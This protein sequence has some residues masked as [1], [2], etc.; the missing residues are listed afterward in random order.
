M[1]AMENASSCTKSSYHQSSSKQRRSG[2]EPSDTETDWQESPWNEGLSISNRPRTPPGPARAISPLN[3]SRR[4]TLKEES[5]YPSVKA[6]GTSSATRR[7]SRSP[8]KPIRGAGDVPYSD[9]RRN[10]SPLKVSEHRRHVSPYKAK[11]E[12]SEH[13]NSELNN[14]FRK[15][16]QRTPPKIHNS[17]QNDTHSQL[18]EVSR[19]NER[20]KY[21]RNRSMSTPKLRARETTIHDQK[22]GTYAGS[23][24]PKEINEVIAS[25]KLSKSPS[26]D[27]HLTKSTDSVSFGDIFFSRDCTIPQKNSDMNNSNNGKNFAPG[28]KAVLERNATLHQESRGIKSSDQNRQAI[29]VRTVLSQTNTSFVSAAGQLS[30]GQTNTSS[31]SAIGRLSR[32]SNDTG[33]FSDGSGKSGSFRKF[34]ANIQRSQTEAWLSC[35]RKGSCRKS[36]LPEYRAIDEASFIEK[37]FVVEELRMFWADKHRPHSLNGFICHKQQTQHLRQLI[38][39]N[40]FPHLLFKGPSGSGKKSLCMAFLHEIFGDSSLK[41]SHDLRHFH[42]QESRPVQI[43]VPLT[44]GPHHFELNLKSQSKNARYA[45]MALVKEIVGNCAD[46][47]EVS[48][49]SLKMNYKVIVLH[50]V[51]KATENV[52]HLIKWIMD[53]YTDA[54]KI[55]LCCEDDTNLLHSIKSRCKL[56]AMDA[57]VTH[58]MM[59]VLIQI[60]KKENFELSTSFAARIATRSKQNLRRAIMALEACKA[61]NYPFVDDQPMP[62]DWEDVLGE[63]AAEILADPSPKRL[64][65][66]RGKLQKLLVEFV[67]PKLIL[68]KLVE[69][70]LKGIEAGLKRELYYWHAYYDKRLPTGTSALLKLEEFVAKFMSIHRKSF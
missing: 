64:F 30:S 21:S 13:E 58:E 56:I 27:A 39:H 10:T 35:V 51:D 31:N 17:A 7:H 12:Q 4:N 22:D 54:C 15:R 47:P 14:S 48:D 70:F 63:L 8:Y 11:T 57:P 69:Q 25:R 34:T 6:L 50:D 40:S 29:S 33:K 55:I 67:H 38:S 53:C 60:A 45:L 37:A 5:N 1:L 24:S 20:S 59:E 49:A 66:I 43:V 3:H 36:K 18:Q 62:L 9:L 41:V 52:Q 2:Y 28:I 44:S 32:T 42:V 23:S 68:Q 26:Y 61:H 16:S 46:I 65:S 19:V